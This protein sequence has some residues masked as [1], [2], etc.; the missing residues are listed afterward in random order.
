M[1]E[2]VLMSPGGHITS[3]SGFGGYQ[4]LLRGM[5]TLYFNNLIMDPVLKLKTNLA[6]FDQYFTKFSNISEI[7]PFVGPM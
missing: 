1:G 4:S 3:L 2:K 6:L 5:P 7:S